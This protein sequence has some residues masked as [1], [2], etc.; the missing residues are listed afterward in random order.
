LTPDQKRLE[1]VSADP[2]LHAN[3]YWE[4]KSFEQLPYGKD[5]SKEENGIQCT[6]RA[7]W[8]ADILTVA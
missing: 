1:L 5:P 2:P 8:N 7:P 6:H 4:F 3:E